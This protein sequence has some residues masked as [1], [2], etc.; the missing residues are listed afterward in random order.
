MLLPSDEPVRQMRGDVTMAAITGVNASDI[1]ARAVIAWFPP[2]SALR[3]EADGNVTIRPPSGWAVCDGT[4]GTS[5]LSHRFIMGV[6][7]DEKIGAGGSATPSP[8]AGVPPARRWRVG[9]ELT[10]ADYG[11]GLPVTLIYIIKL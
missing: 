4:K 10:G 2:P 3:R 9:G 5:D 7:S 8:N 11:Y 1:S 6:A